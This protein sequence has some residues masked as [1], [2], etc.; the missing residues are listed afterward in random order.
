MKNRYLKDKNI[1]VTGGTGALGKSLCTEFV[2]NGANVAFSWY[3][4]HKTATN[5]LNRLKKINPNCFKICIDITKNQQ[6][7][8]AIGDL[9]T[10]MER[11]DILVNNSGISEALPFAFIE[12]NDWNRV[13]NVNIKG[14][15]LITRSVVPHMVRQRSGKILNISSIAG[16]RMIEAPI[17]YCAS[18]AA[19]IGF[20]QSMAKEVGRYHIQVNCLA[21]GLLNKGVAE[22][23]PSN[24]LE[25]YLEQTALGRVG[26][27][28]EVAKCASFL[29]SDA[30][31][32]MT[33]ATINM[34]GGL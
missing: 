24:K 16:A 22:K 13:M 10:L 31:S 18:K 29:V 12:E 4:S 15:F 14:P 23:L 33:G 3:K 11:I 7:K 32:Y 20:T 17:H 9:L 19:L 25:M 34:D 21:P 2:K 5:L 26:D 28:E 27:V 6:V 1:L 8:Q 30:N